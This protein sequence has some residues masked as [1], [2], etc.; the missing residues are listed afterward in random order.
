[1]SMTAISAVFELCEGTEVDTLYEREDYL[2]E[3]APSLNNYK[4]ECVV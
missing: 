1:M 4:C 2:C 3:A